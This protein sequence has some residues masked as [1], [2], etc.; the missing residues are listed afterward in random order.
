MERA[1]VLT[2]QSNRAS[3][4]GDSI[5]R[6]L[7]L[8]VCVFVL[9]ALRKTRPRNSN[10]SLQSFLANILNDI[11]PEQERPMSQVVAKTWFPQKDRDTFEPS[12]SGAH[13]SCDSKAGNMLMQQ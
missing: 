10:V 9:A 11:G 13:T 8:A 5:G 4:H 12:L 3:R 7:V 6:G 2:E 1:P